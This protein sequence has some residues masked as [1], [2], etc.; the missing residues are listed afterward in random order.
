MI[1]RLSAAQL[2]ADA[3]CVSLLGPESSA[4]GPVRAAAERVE[5]R[6]PR[7]QPTATAEERRAREQLAALLHDELTLCPQRVRA[8]CLRELSRFRGAASVV[9]TVHPDDVASLEPSASVCAEFELF[10]LEIRPDAT[11]TRGGCTI[12]SDSGEVD[13]RIETRIAR[14]LSLLYGEQ[15]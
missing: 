5:E 1:H 2:A 12:A 8:L 4:G 15:P 14:M 13:A 3:A 11:L 6:Q 7:R 9:L 10:R